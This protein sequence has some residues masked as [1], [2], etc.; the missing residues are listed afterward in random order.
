MSKYI[1]TFRLNDDEDYDIRLADVKEFL[2]NEST[3][4]IED[5]T[6]STIF[7][8]GIN[9]HGKLSS[10]GLLKSSDNVLFAIL[11]DSNKLIKFTRVKGA[12]LYKVSSDI[13]QLFDIE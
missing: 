9:L 13:R 8:K 12:T 3:N 1:I 2:E 10:S 6:T 7:C 4:Y 5:T 11:D